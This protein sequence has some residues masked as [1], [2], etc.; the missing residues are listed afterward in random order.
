MQFVSKSLRLL[1][2]LVSLAL[3][4]AA[5]Q[6]H[7]LLY[8][9]AGGE[10]VTVRFHFAGTDEQPWFEPYEVFAPG[11]TRPHQRGLVNADGEL[12][13]RPNVPGRWQV[14]VA[15]EDG[16]GAS[17]NVEVSEP[18]RLETSVATPFAQRVV[19]AFAILFGIFG[20]VVL[21]RDW[22]RRGRAVERM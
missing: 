6:A 9:V 8:E 20:V 14:R 4:P 2:T 17:V 16:H 5:A 7:A 19:T 10:I 11:S 3:L 22:R 13:F 18:G 21:V 15:T 1:L 12:T